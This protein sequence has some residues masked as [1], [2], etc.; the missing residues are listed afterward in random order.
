M[1]RTIVR[2]IRTDN[3]G[4]TATEY[5]L[6]ASLIAVAVASGIASLGNEVG[7][8]YGYIEDEVASTND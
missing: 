6:I 8:T 3:G 1:L 4:S 5:A 7:S 2:R